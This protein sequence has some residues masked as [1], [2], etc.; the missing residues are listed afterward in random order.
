MG[1]D[2]K[3]AAAAEELLQ[4]GRGQAGAFRRVRAAAE[5][6]QQDQAVLAAFP[7]DPDH[8]GHVAG[9]GGQVLADALAVADIA[10]HPVHHPDDGAF[11]AGDMEPAL[12]HQGQQADGFEADGFSAGVR[13]GDRDA[14]IRQ[15][16]VQAERHAG[17]GVQQ[18]MPGF[19]QA[20]PASGGDFRRTG[21]HLQAQ[22]CP[23]K[24]HIQVGHD[25]DGILQRLRFGGNPVAELPEDAA[26]FRI[27]I[28]QQLIQIQ[29]H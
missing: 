12:G 29:T 19:R 27:N 28:D 2:H 21:V 13:P 20:D 14:G 26:F 1:G 23:G 4:D 16:Q 7:E 18:R 10:E 22:L 3:E 6:V 11:P 17:P 24:D 5:L 9:E 15:G 8:I 25:A